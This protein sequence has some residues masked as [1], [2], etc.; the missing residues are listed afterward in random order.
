MWAS[1]EPTR[2]NLYGLVPSS[3]SSARPF[4]SASRAY[5]NGS[6]P[7]VLSSAQ[8]EVANVPSLVVGERVVGREQRV[9]LAVALDLGPP[10]RA[11]PTCRAPRRRRRRARGRCMGVD[12]EHQAVREIAVVG[13]GQ[14]RAAGRPLVVLEPFV[15]VERVGGADRRLGGD[16]HDLARPLG[17]VAEDDVAV[18]VVAGD[19]R[20][21]LEADDGGEGAGVVELL[22]SVDDA[23]PDRR[24]DLGARRILVDQPLRQRLLREVGD[25]VDGGVGGSLAAGLQALVPLLASG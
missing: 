20:G 1:V 12:R 5:S 4:F 17:A 6:I 2:P 18:Q 15:E 3:A 21:P 22:G 25:Q 23:F 8:V 11:A 16:R 13:D 24:V 19:E 7:G 10:R 9:G 14:R